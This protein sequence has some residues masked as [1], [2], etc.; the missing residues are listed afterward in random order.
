MDKV[1]VEGV[2]EDQ[3]GEKSRKE[4]HREVG[5]EGEEGEGRGRGRGRGRVLVVV[6]K[7][8]AKEG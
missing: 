1:A 2:E 3:R 5:G 7:V 8:M 6:M 4:V